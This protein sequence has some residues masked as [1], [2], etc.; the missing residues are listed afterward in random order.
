M[1]LP[2]RVLPAPAPPPITTLVTAAPAPEEPITVGQFLFIPSRNEGELIVGIKIENARDSSTAV[3]T[4]GE[5]VSGTTLDWT[6]VGYLLT[7][8]WTSGAAVWFVTAMVR[9]ARFQ[10]LLRFARP[11]PTGVQDRAA[12][13]AWKLG[14]GRCPEVAIVP[15]LVPPMVCMAVG[16]PKIYLPGEL[17]HSLDATERDTLL[18]HELAH[19]RRRDHW[20]RWL[21]ILVQGAF[22]WYPLVPVIRRQ[23]RACEEECC[24]ALVIA[25]LPARTY[26]AA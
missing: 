9:L 6:M 11:A 3:A 16:R 20:V 13:L 5:A 17:L 10:R 23:I 7:G 24:D 14:L 1:P 4:A 8:I 18:A 22:W 15:G 25:V 12:E 21:E 26:V 19:L 2:V